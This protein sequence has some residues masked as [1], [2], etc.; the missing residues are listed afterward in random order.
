M[1]AEANLA[2]FFPP[3]NTQVW[4]ADLLWQPIPVHT[5]PEQVDYVLSG[6]RPCA[7]YTAALEQYKQSPEYVSQMEK[8]QPLFDY[9]SQHVGKKI[10]SV[11]DARSIYNALFIENLK[12][13][14]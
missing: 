5:A 3:R 13:M 1:S 4:N 6:K 10:R 11:K 9:L 8:F 12:N 2:G 14:T 7:R